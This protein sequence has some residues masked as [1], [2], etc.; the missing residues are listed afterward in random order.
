MAS[1]LKQKL[2]GA[3]LRQ[4]GRLKLKMQDLKIKYAK[5]MKKGQIWRKYGLQKE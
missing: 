1:V 4:G 5:K 2:D 3:G